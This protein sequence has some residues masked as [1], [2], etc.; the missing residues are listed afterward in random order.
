[1]FKK[2]AEI[3]EELEKGLN[4]GDLQKSYAKAIGIM[5]RFI[6]ETFSGDALSQSYRP[7]RPLRHRQKSRDQ[8]RF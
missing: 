7:K 2:I 3:R 8:S 1:M 6:L 4:Q 5:A